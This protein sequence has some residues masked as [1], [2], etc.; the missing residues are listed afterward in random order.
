MLDKIREQLPKLP[1]F[2]QGEAIDENSYVSDVQA[3]LMLQSPRG[4]RLIIY[5]MIALTIIAISWSI[6]AKIDDV[7]KAQGQVIPSSHVQ[8]I[9]NLEGGVLKEIFVREGQIIEKGDQLVLIDDVQFGSE[10]EKSFLEGI[11]YELSLMRLKAEVAGKDLIIPAEVVDQ[12]PEISQQQMAL[13]RTRQANLNKQLDVLEFAK[14]QKQQELSQHK[15]KLI[16]AREKHNLALQEL[17]KLEPLLATGAV[18]EMEILQARQKA[19]NTKA[20]VTDVSYGIP[21]LEAAVLEAQGRIDQTIT[22]FREEAEREL[23][24]ISAKNKAVTAMQKSLKDKVERAGVR[25][26]VNG[27]VKKIYVDTIGGTIKP[28]M[29]IMEIVPLDDTLL[30]ETKVLPKDIGFIRE[31]QKAT[32]KLSAYDYSVYGGIEGH[33]ERV[34]ADSTTDEKGRTFFVINVSIPQNYIGQPEDNLLIIPGMQ[35]EIDVVVSRRSVI[36]YV[37]RPLLKAKFS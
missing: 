26:P 3:A 15:Q 33:V 29:T 28:G 17:K 11:G 2:K 4:G 10:L 21:G 18:S 16:S 20:E 7:V 27:T 9:Q 13:Y 34:S 8:E 32:V 19:A 30:I 37:L 36:D 5:V 6:L 14:R 25:S 12:Y 35:A 23:N 24:D 1:A 22:D 31:G